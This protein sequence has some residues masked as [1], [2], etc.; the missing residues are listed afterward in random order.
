MYRKRSF[1]TLPS[2]IT[3]QRAQAAVHPGRSRGGALAEDLDGDVTLELVD[4]REAPEPCLTAKANVCFS[5][6][7]N[8]VT[9]WLSSSWMPFGHTRSKTAFC[10]PDCG[11]EKS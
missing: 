5:S 11:S 1:A 2:G 6:L 3:V 4:A 9:G 10:S 7:S 8:T